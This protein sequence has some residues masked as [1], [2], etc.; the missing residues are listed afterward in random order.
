[1]LVKKFFTQQS[2][3]TGCEG[4]SSRGPISDIGG[5]FSSTHADILV[6]QQFYTWASG[7]DL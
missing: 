1:M 5:G 6:R 2:N 4:D 7:M 3:I